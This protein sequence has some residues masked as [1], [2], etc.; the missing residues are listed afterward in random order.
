MTV[1]FKLSQ[2][3]LTAIVRVGHA[4]L[5]SHWEVQTMLFQYMHLMLLGD[6]MWSRF[7]L[8]L[9]SFSI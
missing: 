2:T 9:V 3:L 5:L 7:Q 1:W 6:Q 4:Q 8:K